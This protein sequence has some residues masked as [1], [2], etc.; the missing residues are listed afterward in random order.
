[1][2]LL[3]LQVLPVPVFC[4]R[5]CVVSQAYVKSHKKRIIFL[6]MKSDST[7]LVRTCSCSCFGKSAITLETRI[8]YSSSWW[9]VVRNT[10]KKKTL[11]KWTDNISQCFEK[12][13]NPEKQKHSWKIKWIIHFIISFFN[14]QCGNFFSFSGNDVSYDP[15]TARTFIPGMYFPGNSKEESVR[16]L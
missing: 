7:I 5:H 6:C 13:W 8:L 4:F 10:T 11:G 1:M 2:F 12:Q 16:Q 14:P 3:V 15:K 9:L